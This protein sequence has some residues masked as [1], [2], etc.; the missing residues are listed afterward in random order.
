M[1]EL[2]DYAV[3]SGL[4]TED[5]R[6]WAENRLLELLKLDEPLE[7]PGGLGGILDYAVQHGLCEDNI[8]ARDLFDTKVMSIFTPAPHE[9]RETFRRLYEES[10]AAATDWY[11]KFSQDTNYIRRDRVAKDL[12]WLYN[13]KYGELDKQVLEACRKAEDKISGLPGFPMKGKYRFT[14]NAV[15]TMNV[16]SDFYVKVY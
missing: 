1:K 14:V 4:I 6:L 7:I 16:V 15:Y 2:I 11:Y 9:V 10:P 8:T 13:G 3:F 12:K 5:D